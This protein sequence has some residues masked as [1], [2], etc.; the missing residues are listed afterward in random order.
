M[1]Q[2]KRVILDNVP[3]NETEATADAFQ[4]ILF[5]DEVVE[6]FNWPVN[7]RY[8]VTA[9]RDLRTASCAKPGNAHEVRLAWQM[10]L[11][12]AG[13]ILTGK[14]I[15]TGTWREYSPYVRGTRDTPSL[16]TLWE[17]NGKAV[18]CRVRF[19]RD[20]PV[21]MIFDVESTDGR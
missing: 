16:A 12:T 5:L 2:G 13:P 14:F 3:A 9:L 4:W 18:V 15:A 20:V 10:L 8:L 21:G 7:A 19:D 1:P 11:D 17:G 6:L